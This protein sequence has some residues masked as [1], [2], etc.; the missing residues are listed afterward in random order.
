MTRL[1]EMKSTPLA[2]L[3]DLALDGNGGCFGG[4]YIA[5]SLVSIGF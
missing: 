4:L 5:F 1:Q 3:S 2:I